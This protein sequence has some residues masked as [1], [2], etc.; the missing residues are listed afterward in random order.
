MQCAKCK[1]G[2]KDPLPDDFT[3]TCFYGRKTC[4]CNRCKY[5][6]YQLML[7]CIIDLVTDPYTAYVVQKYAPK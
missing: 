1:R 7:D 4:Q 3:M 5:V 2:H 6:G